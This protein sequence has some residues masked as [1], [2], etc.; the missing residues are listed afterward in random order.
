MYWITENIDKITSTVQYDPSNMGKNYV[1]R[2]YHKAIKYF[3]SRNEPYTRE[4]A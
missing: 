3:P 1:K 2:R 4:N